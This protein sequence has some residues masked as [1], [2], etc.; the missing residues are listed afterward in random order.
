[1]IRDFLETILGDT[2]G[3]VSIWRREEYG[4]KA[5]VNR[6]RWYSWPADIDKMTKDVERN[7]DKDVYVTTAT[8]T[9][10]TRKPHLAL[11][12]QTVWCDADTCDPSLFRIAPSYV[13]Q[14]S[15]GRWQTYWVL[16]APVRAADASRAARLIAHAHKSQ[17]ADISSWPANKIMR[18]PGTSNTNWGFAT[19]VTGQQTEHI[20]SLDDIFEAYSDVKIE[21]DYSGGEASVTIPEYTQ[22]DFFAAQSKL[23]A[24]FPIELLTSEPEVGPDGNR[25]ELRWKMLA[26]LVEAGLTDSEVLTLA[27]NTPAAQKWHD[28]SRGQEG[29]K[30]EIAK[31]RMRYQEKV[32]FPTGAVEA[33]VEKPE[34]TEVVKAKEKPTRSSD[35]IRILSADDRRRAKAH[36][37]ETFLYEYEQWARQY[38]KIYNTR[39]N[40]CGA[41]MALSNMVGDVAR[42]PIEGR[43]VPCN[44]F[45]ITLGETTTGKSQS[46]HLMR[47]AVKNGYPG[48][49]NP[50]LGSNTSSGALFEIIHKR[51][52]QCSLLTSDEADGFLTSLQNKSGWQADLMAKITDL[53]DGL[54]E[55]IQRRGQTDGEW[56]KTSFSMYLMGTEVKVTE[57]LDRTMFESGFLTRVIWFI[58]EKIDVPDD[59]LG[60]R[61]SDRKVMNDQKDK[62]E[63]WRKRFAQ[64]AEHWDLRKWEGEALIMPETEEISDWFQQQTAKIEQGKLFDNT[65]DGRV[66]TAAATRMNVSTSKIAALL[67]LADDRAAISK[68]D[69]LTAIWIMEQSLT[70]MVTVFRKVASSQH[71]KD[72]DAL[73]V[74]AASY[75]TGAGSPDIYR[76]MS[77]KGFSKRDVDGMV[78]ELVAQNRVKYQ[79]TGE[80]TWSMTVKEDG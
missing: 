50:D 72:L 5:D 66:L 35:T 42:I 75:P 12:S 38:L 61:F 57:A 8:Y 63:E 47:T 9:E 36:Y 6:S 27:W 59:L 20:Y 46:K 79:R 68:D 11:Q 55:P 18:I 71:A 7:A 24:D 52:N 67:A 74:F 23:P 73:E 69:F 64:V 1:M 65:P 76:H 70:D 80:A 53:Y 51:P 43:D 45:T 2:E 29:L 78:S 25:S 77:N 37:E 62:P 49:G 14:S 28:D 30:A 22:A 34:V 3:R 15:P 40:L 54:A 16:D 4:P 13:V 44:L 19:T 56:T 58:G 48:I 41:L 17:G 33:E 10:D 21:A 31:E 60:V 39:Y 26:S 32:G